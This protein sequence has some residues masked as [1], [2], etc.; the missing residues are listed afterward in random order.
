MPIRLVGREKIACKFLPRL[1]CFCGDLP[2]P[3]GAMRR[4]S[5]LRCAQCKEQNYGDQ[6]R[7]DEHDRLLFRTARNR[8]MI[9]NWTNIQL[10]QLW[11]VSMPRR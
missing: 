8:V 7:I 6:E 9:Q 3:S 5:R 11:E 4:R 2:E 10:A 1:E